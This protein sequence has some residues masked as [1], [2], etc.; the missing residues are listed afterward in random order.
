MQEEEDDAG[1]AST[2]TVLVTPEQARLLAELEQE[3]S[4]HAA[5]VY[6][7]NRENAGKFLEEQARVLEELYAEEPE[8]TEGGE[9]AEEENPADGERA[10]G[11]SSGEGSAE[12]GENK[13]TGA[14]SEKAGQ[15]EETGSDKADDSGSQE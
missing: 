9:G 3:G 13:P 10:E 2:I 1:L 6:R 7:G 15:S 11:E 8:E 14:E 4:I 12:D 5:L